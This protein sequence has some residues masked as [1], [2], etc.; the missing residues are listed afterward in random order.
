MWVIRFVFPAMIPLILLYV[1][2]YWIYSKVKNKKL[3]NDNPDGGNT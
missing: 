2:G 3:K 1:A